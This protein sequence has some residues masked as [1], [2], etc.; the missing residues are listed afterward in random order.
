MK[1]NKILAITMLLT[2]ACFVCVPVISAAIKVKGQVIHTVKGQDDPCPVVSEFL[3]RPDACQ[4][5]V[6]PEA[7]AL[8]VIKGDEKVEV[9][10]GQSVLLK[11][12]KAGKTAGKVIGV[13][14]TPADIGMLSDVMKGKKRL[15]FW[16]TGEDK[17][18]IVIEP[19]DEFVPE[20]GTKIKIKVKQLRKVEGC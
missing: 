3:A 12:R 11:S 13:L 8:V 16:M 1:T 17:S 9:E 10:T 2:A 14:D 7:I 15:V 20:E 5:G 19:E 18:I 4:T 6:L